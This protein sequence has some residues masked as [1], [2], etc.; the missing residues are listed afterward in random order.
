MTN[1][2]RFLNLFENVSGWRASGQL[3]GSK[4]YLVDIAVQD[5]LG[6]HKR[7]VQLMFLFDDDGKWIGTEEW[8]VS[9]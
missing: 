8:K 2:Q 7:W 4:R 1:L 9:R 5:E 3:Q 6:N